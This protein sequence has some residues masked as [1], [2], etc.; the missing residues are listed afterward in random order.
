MKT[1]ETRFLLYAVVLIVLLM[2]YGAAIPVMLPGVARM[3]GGNVIEYLNRSL[4]A[5]GPLHVTPLFLAKCLLFLL[6]LTVASRMLSRFLQHRV[7]PHI[8]MEPGQRYALARFSS[9]MFFLLGL[10]IGLQ[11]LGVDLSSLVVLAG[12]LGV[13]VGLGLQNV[14]SNFVSGLILLI[15][16]PVKVGDRIEVENTFGE[17]VRIAGRSTWVRTNDNVVIIIPNSEFIAGRVINWTANDRQVRFSVPVGVAY[18]SDPEQVRRA[19][20][21]VAQQNPDVLRDPEPDVIF[22]EFG[23]S[24][25]HFQLR[26]F[27]TSK[28]STPPTFRSDLYFAIFRAFAEK[29]IHIPFP[30]RDLHLR[31]AVPVVVT[32]NA[33]LSA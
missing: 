19:L 15:E 29:G 31:S 22:T 33:T 25:L 16:R 28:V 6:A 9:Y 4:F 26:V 10:A 23:E 7:L 20:L 8:S 13:G 30:Q 24:A 14:V 12:A 18:G 2:L 11:S 21:E 5:I 27:T 3:L 17:V 32:G 1:V